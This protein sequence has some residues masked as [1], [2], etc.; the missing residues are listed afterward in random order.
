MNLTI[1]NVTE[2]YYQQLSVTMMTFSLHTYFIHGSYVAPEAGKQNFYYTGLYNNNKQNIC[3]CRPH[4]L[5]QLDTIKSDFYTLVHRY[6]H[7]QQWQPWHGAQSFL[8]VVGF[9]HYMRGGMSYYV[10][11]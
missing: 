10:L 5:M 7:L 9:P 8:V 2:Q 1:F 6:T 4:T 11:L 3:S